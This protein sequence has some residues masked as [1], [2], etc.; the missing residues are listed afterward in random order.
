[1]HTGIAELLLWGRDITAKPQ[2]GQDESQAIVL[3]GSAAPG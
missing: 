2:T 3:G 1:M